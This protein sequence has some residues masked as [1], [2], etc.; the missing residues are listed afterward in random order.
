MRANFSLNKSTNNNNT[1]MKKTKQVVLE[2]TV[3]NKKNWIVDKA[4]R[5]KVT[6]LMQQCQLLKIKIKK[7]KRFDADIVAMI[8]IQ[9]FHRFLLILVILFF[10]PFPWTINHTNLLRVRVLSLVP[11]V[12]KN[13]TL[14]HA[15]TT[16]SSTGSTQIE[17]RS[18]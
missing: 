12:D 2:Y 14:L 3:K 5:K 4:V 1:T 13:L 6:I 11:R 17:Y 15:R 10:N 7:T 18:T 8:I 9:K 16:S